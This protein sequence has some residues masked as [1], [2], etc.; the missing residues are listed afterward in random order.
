MAAVL[1]KDEGT[2]AEQMPTRRA[3]AET[4]SLGDRWKEKK[5]GL[6]QALAAQEALAARTRRALPQ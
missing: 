5:E 1:V 3:A 4:A 2:I 6:D